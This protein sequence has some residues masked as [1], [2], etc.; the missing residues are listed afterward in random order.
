[1]ESVLVGP[2]D[3]VTAP[4]FQFR[5]ESIEEPEF[6]RGEDRLVTFEQFSVCRR[7]GTIRPLFQVGSRS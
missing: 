5:I 3:T 6:V 1:M 2:P 7:P 4:S